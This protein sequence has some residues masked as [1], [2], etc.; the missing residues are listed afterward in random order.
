MWDNAIKQ[1]IQ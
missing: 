1:N